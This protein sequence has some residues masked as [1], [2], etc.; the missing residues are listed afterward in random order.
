MRVFFGLL[1]LLSLTAQ[2]QSVSQNWICVDLDSDGFCD[3]QPV[4][5]SVAKHVPVPAGYSVIFEDLFDTPVANGLP[6]SKWSY[7]YEHINEEDQSYVDGADNNGH[8]KVA[9]RLVDGQMRNV[10]VLTARKESAAFT[11]QTLNAG[12]TQFWWRSGGIQ[13]RLGGIGHTKN[14]NYTNDP[15]NPRKGMP[16]GRYEIRAK[17]PAGRGTFPALWLLGRVNNEFPPFPNNKR[18]WPHAGELDIMEYLGREEENGTYKTHHT[19]HRS[20]DEN[21]WPTNFV[22]HNT[23][24][25]GFHHDYNQPVSQNWHV[26]R[27]DWFEDRIVWYVDGQIVNKV[28][29]N[30]PGGTQ[31]GDFS[32]YTVGGLYKNDPQFDTSGAIGWPWDF[33]NNNNFHLII[34]LA[35]ASTWAGDLDPNGPTSFEFLIDYVRVYAPN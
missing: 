29:L 14:S 25:L 10:L 15:A 21:N 12:S 22:T 30:D 28:N 7:L 17:V 33:D 34:N 19:V 9:A 32:E 18:G 16:Y 13:T 31:F 11:S 3:M 24:P 20:S 27:V 1:L 5:S 26:F 35:L 2:A 8:I 23:K 6:S 4:Q